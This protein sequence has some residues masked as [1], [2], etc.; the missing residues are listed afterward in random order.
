MNANIH[1]ILHFS[2][3]LLSLP[4]YLPLFLPFSPFLPL[5]LTDTSKKY[6]LSLSYSSQH[7]SDINKYMSPS[8]CERPLF[9]AKQGQQN[10]HFFFLLPLFF[11]G[12]CRFKMAFMTFRDKLMHMNKFSLQPIIARGVIIHRLPTLDATK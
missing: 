4:L 3:S 7:I 6:T 10:I 1:P 12:N 2:L 5:S 9:I 8:H 11:L